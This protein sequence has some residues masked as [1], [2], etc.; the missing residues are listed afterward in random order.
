MSHFK[1]MNISGGMALIKY[2]TVI[3]VKNIVDSQTNY[4]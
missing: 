2:T 4:I 3:Q 1:V